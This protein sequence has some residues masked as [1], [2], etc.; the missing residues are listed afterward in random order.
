MYAAHSEVLRYIKMRSL[1]IIL[2][3]SINQQFQQS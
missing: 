3:P 1:V 2:L